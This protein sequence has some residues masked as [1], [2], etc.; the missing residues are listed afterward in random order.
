M[1]NEPV[2]D[3]LLAQAV[4]KVLCRALDKMPGNLPMPVIL[5]ALCQVLGELTAFP[6][7]G[8]VAAR[9]DMLRL[10]EGRVRHYFQQAVEAEQKMRE[11]QA[12]GRVIL[13][14][15]SDVPS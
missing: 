3:R 15:G 10:V 4:Y 1:S 14:P 5:E 6:G 7:F 13:S 11:A 2:P 8:D 12:E 9:E